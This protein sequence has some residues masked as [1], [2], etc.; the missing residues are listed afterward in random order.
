MKHEPSVRIVLGCV[1]LCHGF[2][3]SGQ[4]QEPPNGSATDVETRAAPWRISCATTTC[5]GAIEGRGPAWNHSVSTWLAHDPHAHAGRLL[6]DPDSRRIVERLAVNAANDLK[7][8][9]H[10]LKTRCISCH[11]SATAKDCQSSGAIDSGLVRRGVHCESCHGE[12][13]NWLE[14]HLRTDWTGPQRFVSTGMRDTES[15][16]GRASTCVRCHVGSRS[17]DGVIRDM[18]HD[19]IAAGH[20]AL[21]F[22][23]LLYNENLPKH[24]DVQSKSER[25]F[26]RSAL[27]VRQVGRAINLVAAASLASERADDHLSDRSAAPWPE[28]SD[29]DCF[30]CH[31]S[32]SMREYLLPP[33]SDGTRK[34]PLHVS[35]GL[36]VWNS[37]HTVGNELEMRENR[38]ALE[39]L[40]PHRS[41]PA[42]IAPLAKQIAERFLRKATERMAAAESDAAIRKTAERT[43]QAV[44]RDLQASA[45]HDWQQA[46]IQYL[47]LDAAARDLQRSRETERRGR[48]LAQS[49]ARIE[50]LL[51][52]DSHDEVAADMQRQSP[53]HFDP[54]AFRVNLLRLLNEWNRGEL[55]AGRDDEHA[56]TIP[57]SSS[58]ALP[59]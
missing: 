48:S 22:D 24:W 42:K 27:R 28:F 23:L 9:D 38:R 11:T 59:R 8:Y 35:D 12:A 2:A 51:R 44:Q 6:R 16:I 54:S 49:L 3:A 26:S 13:E 58:A 19:L 46:A 20:P 56:T 14:L 43:I 47:D 57:D 32:L 25:G 55:R 34:T 1:L 7:V 18:N 10:V 53:A 29:Y 31:Q 30:A 15:I 50:R 17:E 40:S 36:P 41:D 52:F 5:H 45:P 37:W 33:R 4:S 21:R 39:V